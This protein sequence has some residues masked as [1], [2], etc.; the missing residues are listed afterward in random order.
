MA[1]SNVDIRPT[2]RSFEIAL[3]SLPELLNVIHSTVPVES[4]MVEFWN[5]N[6]IFA[7]Y[8]KSN[9]EKFIN[10]VQDCLSGSAFGPNAEMRW[11]RV[12]E[13][14]RGVF[15]GEINP[16]KLKAMNDAVAALQD[17]STSGENTS[18]PQQE[19]SVVTS[20][21]KWTEESSEEERCGRRQEGSILLWGTKY[22]ETSN[23]WIEGRIPRRL[24]Y[25]VIPEIRPEVE[26]DHVRVHFI[27]YFDQRGRVVT[28]RRT[29]LCAEQRGPKTP[30]VTQEENYA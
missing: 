16:E 27:E 5:G 21:F 19:E 9:V 24:Q 10:R 22:L 3:E 1:N 18:E 26:Y 17:A 20:A 12:S 13:E 8:C 29:K 28:F 4:L 7:D 15:V 6:D 23:E 14:F 2:I 30:V 11:R 25:P